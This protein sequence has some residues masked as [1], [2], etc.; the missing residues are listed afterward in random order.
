MKPGDEFDIQRLGM[1]QMPAEV[2]RVG[3]DEAMVML[4]GISGSFL[5]D[6]KMY[7]TKSAAMYLTLKLRDLEET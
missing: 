3:D 1:A 2:V 6:G 4:K 7:Q 5:I